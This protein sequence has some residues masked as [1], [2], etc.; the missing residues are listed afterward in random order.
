MTDK[1]TMKTVVEI[2]ESI[3]DF[4]KQNP[5]W[6]LN[7]LCTAL[8]AVLAMVV[9]QNASNENECIDRIC[10]ISFYMKNKSCQFFLDK[11]ENQKRP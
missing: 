5:D 11:I 8:S 3:I 4:I 7:P 1:E 10:D 9:G 6:E 2:G